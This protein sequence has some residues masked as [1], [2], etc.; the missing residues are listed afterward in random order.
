MKI[1]LAA[2]GSEFTPATLDFIGRMPFPPGSELTVLTVIPDFDVPPGNG[3][4][5]EETESLR[6]S[7]V[8]AAD[9]V[10]AGAA[11]RAEAIG[12]PVTRVV[13]TGHFANEII[14]CGV[15]LAADLI[16]VG[17]HGR[18]GFRRFLLGSISEKVVTYAPCSVLVVRPTAGTG[19]PAA[20]DPL[21]VLLATDGSEPAQAAIAQLAALS[22]RRWCEIRIVTVLELVTIYHMEIRQRLTASW[23]QQKT[24]ARLL[25]EDA[26]QALSPIATSV[27]TE[28]IEAGSPGEAI[29][30]RA[31]DTATD[32]IVLGGTGRGRMERVLLGSVSNQVAR[33]ATCPV[34]I[35]RRR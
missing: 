18:R 22:A 35:G 12:L 32:L 15:E 14:D 10:V 6:A 34:W 5:K 26:E 29:V 31:T 3:H 16:V 24:A 23:R 8:A 11:E 4:D 9:R 7:L 19:R 33:D 13:R 20:S 30:D 25:L 1:L 28:V 2:D 27:T 21:R 17:S